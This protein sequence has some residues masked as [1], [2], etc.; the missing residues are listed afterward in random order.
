MQANVNISAETL[1]WVVAHTR[2]DELPQKVIE[3]FDSWMNGTKAP[4]FN[5]V[6]ES[7]S[8]FA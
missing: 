4:T 2:M 8:K 1:N 6:G 5:R 3:Y 7:K